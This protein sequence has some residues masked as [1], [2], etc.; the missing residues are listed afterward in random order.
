VLP[1]AVRHFIGGKHVYSTLRKSYGVTDP[2]TGKEYAQ[3]EVGLG[4]D[5]NQAVL[6]ARTAL[7]TGPW[8]G[9]AASDRA[10][11]LSGIADAID[12]RADDITQAQALGPGLPVTQGREQAARAGEVFRF[13]ADLVT[14]Q[15]GESGAPG[16]TSYVVTQPAGVAGLITS[17]RTP[18]VSQARVVAPALAAGAA[19]V[20]KPDEWAPL[21]AALLAEITTAAGLPD[22]VLNV[23]HGSLHRKAPGAQARDALVGHPSVARLSFAGEA[24]PGHQVTLDAAAHGKNLTAELAGGSPCLVFADADLDQAADSALFGAFALN[25][26]RRTA[27]STVLVQRPVYDTV[28]SRLAERAAHI[29]TGDPADPA[30]QVGPL[31][32]ADQFDKLSS[33]V[34]LAIREGARLAAGGRRPADLPEGSYLAP[35]VLADVTPSMPVYAAPAC[36]PVLRVTPFDTDDEAVSL[37]N[38]VSRHPAAYLW[39]ADLERARH[40]A[41][42][43]ES[44]G[45]WVNSHNPRDLQTATAVPGPDGRGTAAE[46]VNIGFYAQSRT[47]VIA[48]DDPPG[49]RF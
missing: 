37:A 19:I 6:A 26:Q 42:A 44:A 12:A 9:M 34:R 23:V 25:G 17:W 27:T 4:A 29:R 20:L 22:G 40:L 5:V 33:F 13:V 35:T 41:P 30:T 18:F 14:T 43:I 48:A 15:A 11:V 8:A 38:A 49:P 7:E 32:H 3:V 39:T 36:G 47:V 10:R 45:T 28:V 21:P 31:P 16:A 24:D 2:A 46:D 1:E